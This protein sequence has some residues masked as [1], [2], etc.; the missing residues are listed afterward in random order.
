MRG[1]HVEAKCAVTD[2]DRVHTIGSLTCNARSSFWSG[3]DQEILYTTQQTVFGNSEDHGRHQKQCCRVN[4]RS[5]IVAKAS[6][7]DQPRHR[8]ALLMLSLAAMAARLFG[9][10]LLELT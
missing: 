3:Q 9:P 8:A 7:G 2:T 4:C 1:I 5:F 10:M 6:V